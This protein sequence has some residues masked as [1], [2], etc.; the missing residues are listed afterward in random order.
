[1]DFRT[2]Y[3]SDLTS[4]IIYTFG[5]CALALSSRRMTGVRWFAVCMVAGLTKT[6]L[7]AAMGKIPRFFTMFLANEINDLAFLAMFLGFR[8]FLVRKTS[9]KDP[10]AIVAVAGMLVYA[11]A[12]YGSTPWQ[13]VIGMIPVFASCFG[14][15]YLLLRRGVGQFR[16]AARVTACFFAL[17]IL[18]AGY[19]TTIITLGALVPGGGSVLKVIDQRWNISMMAL[20]VLDSCFVAAFLWFYMIELQ[21]GL[22][23]QTRTDEL[24]GALNRRA[25][26]IEAEREIA[27][28]N[29]SGQPVSLLVLDVDHFKRL[30]D[31]RGHAAGDF[32]LQ[33]LV[34]LLVDQL[35]SQ[36]LVARTGG[37]EFLILLPDTPFKHSVEVAERLRGAIE[38]EI[39]SYE[40]TALRITASI[41]VAGYRHASGDTWDELRRRGDLA[42]Y[43][44]KNSGRNRI[45]AA[46]PS[47]GL[48]VAE[49][50]A[51]RRAQ[52]EEQ[53]R[54]RSDSGLRAASQLP[55]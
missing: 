18:V 33:R 21:A 17:Q 47:E 6:V 22:R 30:N 37:E 51:A 46:E 31:T 28:A 25:I 15:L 27:R 3:I 12:R 44:A 29:R 2:L 42:M 4:L 50:A 52:P 54:R 20:M 10:V 9:R 38:R 8:W 53:L 23:H 36:D 26:D 49:P 14:S 43:Q 1:M 40:G 5:L 32:A 16:V 41:G 45:A 34:A 7:Q 11:V 35:R 19:R 24:T 48:S 55:S 13:F 39:F